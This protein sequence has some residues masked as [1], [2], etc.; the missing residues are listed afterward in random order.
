MEQVKLN[1]QA[2]NVQSDDVLKHWSSCGCKQIYGLIRDDD[3]DEALTLRLLQ[4]NI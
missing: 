3:D 2:T 1:Q 4:L